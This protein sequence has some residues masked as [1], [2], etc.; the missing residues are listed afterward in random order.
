[1]RFGACG[2]VR[3]ELAARGLSPPA[4]LFLMR[5]K[6]ERSADTG[7][8]AYPDGHADR[9]AADNGAEHDAKRDAQRDP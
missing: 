5:R 8:S 1:M 4:A 2:P 6:P 3:T 7:S 9:V